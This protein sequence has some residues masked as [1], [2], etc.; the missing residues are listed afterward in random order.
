MA[1]FN[2]KSYILSHAIISLWKSELCGFFVDFPG[3]SL[4]CNIII[5]S[6]GAA[7]CVFGRRA[8]YLALCKH[9]FIF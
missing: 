4:V 9:S 5:P 8:E 2:L 7:A 6:Q 1:I 3:H